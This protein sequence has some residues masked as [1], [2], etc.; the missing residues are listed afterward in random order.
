MKILDRIN[1]SD[2]VKKLKPDEL[3]PLCAEIREYI[4]NSVSQTGGHLASN[5]GSV[6]LTVALHRVY[7]TSK[8]RIVFDV[9]HQSY[10]H[11]IITGRRDAFNTLRCH[12]GLSGFPK[13]YEAED[14]AFIA[15]HASNSVSVAL[16]MAR[17]RTIS[18]AD[19]KVAAVIGDGA[20]TGGLAYEGLINAGGSDEP[21]VIILNDNGMSINTNVGG[22]AKLLSKERL[23]PAYFNFKRRYRS[24]LE[25]SPRIYHANHKIKEAVKRSL[26]PA[27][28]FDSIGLY[29]LGPVDGHDVNQLETVIG[30]AKDMKIPVLV[31]VITQKGKGCKYAEE[32]PD[33]YH[34]VGR[35]N[36]E[37][38]EL[39]TSKPSF[40]SAFGDKLCEIAE[41]NEKVVAISA[42]MC[43]GTGLNKFAEKY[44]KRFFDV[45]IAE[46]QAVAMAAGMAK[47][48]IVPVVA[49]YSSFLQRAYDMLIHDVS[50]Q[51]LHVVFCV[52]RAGLVGADG[53][54]HHGVFDISYLSSVPGMQILCPANFKELEDMLEKAVSESN[55]PV[56]I[57]YPRGGEGAF[58]ENCGD[59]SALLCEGE[60]LTIAAYGT[61]VNTALE[62]ADKLLLDGITA[63]VIKLGQIKPLD[64]SLVMKSLKKT[65]RL[66]VAEDVC[67]CSCI[68][69]QLVAQAEI[70]GIE[71][72][73]CVLANLG[74][75]I[76]SH[77]TVNE[78]MQDCGIDSD[79]LKEKAIALIRGVK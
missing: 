61:M 12:G 26:L 77:G 17:A 70:E 32:H 30:W 52:D 9:G 54:T 35:F 6:E 59:K 42:A 41:T 37:T 75:G 7:D 1:S 47:Q 55:G 74:D 4:I 2:D 36:P 34:G 49:L 25:N 3:E 53:E 78:L 46:Q 39:P 45:G 73:G 13:P 65:G 10:A 5:L 21:M 40:S 72:R 33:K 76:V 69:N 8:D 20:L 51:N 68:G 57:R 50:L 38:G 29:Y 24:L 62:L 64:G 31:H 66:L 27:N 43:S 58:T 22:V 79:S 28:M 16:G 23:K 14:D 63:E 48:G 15:G 60:D 18:N 67:A 56:A 71:L 19:Y 44:P 11:K